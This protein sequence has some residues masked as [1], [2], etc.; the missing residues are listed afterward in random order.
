M[1]VCPKCRTEN[2]PAGERC[3]N[4]GF[5]LLPTRSTGT[6]VAALIMGLVFVFIIFV[7]AVQIRGGGFWIGLFIFGALAAGCFKM[8]GAGSIADRYEDR[9]A[10]YKES[11]PEQAIA[12]YTKAIELGIKSTTP[13]QERAKLYR[14][15][16]RR[17]EALRDFEDF[18]AKTK[19]KDAFSFGYYSSLKKDI[20]KEIQAIRTEL[21]QMPGPGAVQGKYCLHC[22]VSI[23]LDAAYCPECGRS[24]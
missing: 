16:G 23:P 21:S 15:L 24:Q 19:P 4:C 9:A 7:L 5:N 8:A 22:G 10:K 3:V 20:D 2:S 14:K 6:R 13:I 1:I 18:L 12:D 17:Q 11:D